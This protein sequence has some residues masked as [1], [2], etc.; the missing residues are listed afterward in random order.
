MRTSRNNT[1]IFAINSYKQTRRT[2]D[3]LFR[4]RMRPIPTLKEL[5]LAE[6]SAMGGQLLFSGDRSVSTNSYAVQIPND[7]MSHFVWLSRDARGVYSRIEPYSILG[8]V[9]FTAVIK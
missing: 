7:E 2:A 9:L 6:L 8:P 3:A 1:V 5:T 4:F